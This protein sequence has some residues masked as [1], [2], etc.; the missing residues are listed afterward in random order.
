MSPKEVAEYIKICKKHGVTD[1]ELTGVLKL[2]LSPDV[3]PQ[4][5]A[6]P[7]EPVAP[8][9]SGLTDEDVLFWS[10]S[11]IPSDA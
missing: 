1:L 8:E 6:L 5:Q 11:G 7:A 3:L 10:S 4:P 2:K 9:A